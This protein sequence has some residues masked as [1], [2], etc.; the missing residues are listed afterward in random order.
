MRA[1]F[2]FMDE[3]F[4]E[5]LDIAALTGVLVPLEDYVSVRDAISAIA[6]D[7]LQPPAN[8]IPQPVELHG[9][10]LLRGIGGHV[11]PDL[12]QARL[13]VFKR[14]VELVNSRRLRICRIAYTNH[15][16]VADVF[17]GDPALYGLTFFGIET[18]LGQLMTD[19]LV[20]PVMDGIPKSSHGSK[21][22][23]IDPQLIR[24]FA[25]SVR[26]VH[27]YRASGYPERTLS[28]A[29]PANLGEPLFGD[30]TH[31]TLL[32]LADLVSYL[33]H[34]I[35][36]ADLSTVARS[37]FGESVLRIARSIDATLIDSWRGPLLRLPENRSPSGDAP[38]V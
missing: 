3:C 27:H 23:R 10:N 11:P 24:A 28:I 37:T 15:S 30:S 6:W 36:K 4:S 29:N 1:A 33:L 14:S 18:W 34:Q 7:C 5:T 21:P 8:T 16:E 26:F 19:T 17:V 22:P 12:D 2:L 9:S 38:V 20:I 13:A 31:S 25:Q 35:E 32:Q